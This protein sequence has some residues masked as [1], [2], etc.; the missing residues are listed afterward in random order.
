[1]WFN[2]LLILALSF[3]MACSA[4]AQELNANIIINDAQVQT[5]ERQVIQ[6][7]RDAI[8]NFMNTT[9]WTNDNYKQHERIKCNILITLTGGTDLVNGRYTAN[10]QIQSSRPVY[11]SNYETV[12]LTFFDRNFNFEFFPS[13]PLIFTENLF[14]TNLTAMLAYYAYTILALDA[15]S[16]A[17]QGGN[18]YI[19]RILNILNNSQQAN[20]QG[21]N[22]SDT[23]NRYFISENLNNPQLSGYREA[24]YLYHRKGLDYFA[25]NAEAGRKNILEAIKK[26]AQVNQV[27]PNAVMVNAFF[28]SKAEEIV[29]IFSQADAATRKEAATILTRIDPT[30]AN[31]Y[32]ALER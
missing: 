29:N 5:Q 17:P 11:G 10:V 12:L 2:K 7:L 6:Q 23:R 31:R 25:E 8:A 1:M 3:A 15:D 28:D 21:W 26:I 9:R 27:R 30:N 32:Q 4:L 18:A 14:S 16:F 22:N 24:L 20:A 13:Q 19:E